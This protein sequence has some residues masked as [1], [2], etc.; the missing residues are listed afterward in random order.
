MRDQMECAE[1]EFAGPVESNAE[2]LQLRYWQLC[3]SAKPAL[4]SEE[5]LSHTLPAMDSVVT[6]LRHMHMLFMPVPSLHACMLHTPCLSPSTN[7]Q[8]GCCDEIILST[9]RATM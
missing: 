2:K 1:L 8:G 6:R 4:T 9:L 3:V 7:P 5:H